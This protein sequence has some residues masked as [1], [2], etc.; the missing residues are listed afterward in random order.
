[1][2]VFSPNYPYQQPDNYALL[3]VPERM[4]AP[5]DITGRNVVIAFIDSGFYPHPDLDNR[6]LAHIDVATNQAVESAK[7]VPHDHIYSWHGQMTSVVA[8]GSGLTS[9]GKYRGIAS[10]AEM[11]LVRITNRRGQVKENDILRGLN[12]VIENHRRFDIRIVNVS[13]GGDFETHDPM[14]PLFTAI[15]KLTDTGIVVVTAAGNSGK[16]T[17]LPPASSPDAITVGGFDDRNTL[18]KSKWQGFHHNYGKTYDGKSKPDIIAPAT[19]IASP[20][21]PGSTMEKESRWLAPLLRAPTN[22]AIR[23]ILWNGYA[24]LGFSRTQ[25]ETPD[26]EVLMELQKRLHAHKIIDEHHQHVD[27]TSVST[28]IISSV[29]AQILEINRS[30]TPAQVRNI[31]MTTATHLPNLSPEQQGAGIVNPTQ[32]I[33]MVAS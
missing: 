5:P 9:K 23:Q 27:G 26:L 19:W 11:V 25:A 13:V 33:K 22:E 16:P 32:A 21:M 29:V 24:D 31:L 14:H 3:P 18:D 1:M 30:L 4:S 17:L 6:I 28:A 7:L 20:I 8:T 15:R 2:F 12:W 10:S